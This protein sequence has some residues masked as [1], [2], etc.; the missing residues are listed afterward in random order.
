[1]LIIITICSSGAARGLAE[2]CFVFYRSLML[3]QRLFVSYFDV[4]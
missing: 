2:E 1:M 3:K 4:T